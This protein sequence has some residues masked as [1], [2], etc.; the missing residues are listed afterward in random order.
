MYYSSIVADYKPRIIK[1]TSVQ[2]QQLYPQH[3]KEQHDIIEELLL[4]HFLN[5][6][7]HCEAFSNVCFVAL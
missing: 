4:L 1:Y 6:L 5:S 3:H 2:S 7:N